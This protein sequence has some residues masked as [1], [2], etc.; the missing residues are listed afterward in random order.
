MVGL[1]VWWT[2]GTMT[3]QA[4]AVGVRPVTPREARHRVQA[5]TVRP[6]YTKA[7]VRFTQ[8]MIA[9]HAQALR[10]TR[11]VSARTGRQDL[12]LLAERI[13]VSQ[14][15][16]IKLM[17][18]WL[19]ARHEEVPN[20]DASIMVHDA[21]GEMVLMPGMLSEEEMAQL[22][23]AEATKFDRLFL[24]FMIRHHEGALTMVANLFA[25][26][27]AGQDAEIFQFASDVGADQRAEIR[28]M[29]A[30]L[31]TLK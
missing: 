17:Q 14:R 27:G 20:P 10:M 3:R 1:I 16:E 25:T 7:D 22:A 2:F 11:L 19:A 13:E 26:N 8:G 21:A 24:E 12:R 15:D 23:K 5:D 28:R 29:R 18:R 4:L 6:P 30:V 9:H 31:L